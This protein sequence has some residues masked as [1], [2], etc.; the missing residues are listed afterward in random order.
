MKLLSYLALLACLEG[1]S[2]SAIAF[3]LNP[4][5]V[6]NRL[7]AVSGALFAWWCF[8]L[9]FVYGS[10]DLALSLFLDRLSYLAV[11][12]LSPVLAW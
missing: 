9:V 4:R 8:C 6:L 5:A 2:F 7:G 3:F 12:T 11:L 10:A 1:L